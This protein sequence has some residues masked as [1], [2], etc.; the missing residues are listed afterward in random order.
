MTVII[1]LGMIKISCHLV[2]LTQPQPQSN[3]LW[4]PCYAVLTPH[5]PPLHQI[6]EA[7]FSLWALQQAHA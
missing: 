3:L 4:R 2:A 6:S 1:F 7:H 5:L